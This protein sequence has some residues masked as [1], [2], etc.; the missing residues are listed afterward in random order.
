MEEDPNTGLAAALLN[1]GLAATLPNSG[2]A[3]PLPNSGLAATLPNSDGS[4]FSTATALFPDFTSDS[5]DSFS[6]SACLFPA[7]EFHMASP[8]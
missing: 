3:A 7:N 2:L 5:S 4:P 1:S 8:V 6:L